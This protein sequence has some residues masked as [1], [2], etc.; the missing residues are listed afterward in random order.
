MLQP[1]RIKLIVLLQGQ[2][3][4]EIPDDPLTKNEKFDGSVNV[5]VGQ[6]NGVKVLQYEYVDSNCDNRLADAGL[7]AL[8]DYDN[9]LKL[10]S[11]TTGGGDYNGKAIDVFNSINQNPSGFLSTRNIMDGKKLNTQPGI[12]CENDYCSFVGP[13]DNNYIKIQKMK[14]SED[15]DYT[16]QKEQDILWRVVSYDN[17]N[18]SI[19][20]ITDA[21]IASDKYNDIY[22]GTSA[23]ASSATNYLN[24]NVKTKLEQW[25]NPYKAYKNNSKAIFKSSKYCYT[26]SNDDNTASYNYSSLI[27]SNKSII[28]AQNIKECNYTDINHVKFNNSYVG[29]L[30]EAE[31]IY[32]GANLSTN[33]GSET[34]GVYNNDNTMFQYSLNG[35]WTSDTAYVSKHSSSYISNM[36][37]ASQY[38]SSTATPMSIRPVVTLNGDINISSGNGTKTNPWV[39][40]VD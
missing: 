32:M 40:E 38:S 27:W 24:S 23:E 21:G 29:L 8:E 13:V 7:S 31:Y 10:D 26:I 4:K 14:Y 5:S 19:K 28:N 11:N 18:K 17:L 35:F 30:T 1:S 3:I 9:Y 33:S 22:M 2:Y 6:V 15:I 25:I 37:T 20:I 16:G 39:I 34:Y 36:Y 12:Y